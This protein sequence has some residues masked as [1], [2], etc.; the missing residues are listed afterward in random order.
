MGHT[1][2]PNALPPPSLTKPSDGPSEQNGGSMD[3]PM[4]EPPAKVARLSVRASS[5]KKA[6]EGAAVAKAL[7]R[8]V[9][10][11]RNFSSTDTIRLVMNFIAE[12]SGVWPMLQTVYLPW[13]DDL[14][15]VLPSGGKEGYFKLGE[16]EMAMTLGA[17]RVQPCDT[18]YFSA[19]RDELEKAAG[20]GVSEFDEMPFPWKAWNWKG[21]VRIE[22]L[23]IWKYLMIMKKISC[24]RNAE[25]NGWQK[26]DEYYITIAMRHYSPRSDN[27]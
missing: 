17:L 3:P 2:A 18:I 22:I 4:A 10:A 27:P 25:F 21:Y 15:S 13:S 1:T 14:A 11:S 7:S 16:E 8:L 12:K 19:N 20:D 6:S 24:S 23:L 9:R 5:R 26:L